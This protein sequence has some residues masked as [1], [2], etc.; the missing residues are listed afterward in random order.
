MK[1][2]L[3]FA[4]AAAV[5]YAAALA[6]LIA[7]LPGHLDEFLLTNDDYCYTPLPLKDDDGGGDT[8][9]HV[10]HP[11]IH[12]DYGEYKHKIRM[13]DH[14]LYYDD[15]TTNRE[16]RPSTMQEEQRKEEEV[17]EGQMMINHHGRLLRLL[18]RVTHSILWRVSLHLWDQQQSMEGDNNDDSSITTTTC[19]IRDEDYGQ[20]QQQ[21]MQNFSP[22][23]ELRWDHSKKEDNL[24]S[25]GNIH[26]PTSRSRLLHP[27][28][29]TYRKFRSCV[30]FQQLWL[31]WNWYYRNEFR[32]RGLTL[33]SSSEE[34]VSFV[35]IIREGNDNNNIVHSSS[36]S[37]WWRTMRLWKYF[38]N[39]ARI[40][41]VPRGGGGADGGAEINNSATTE[42]S[43]PQQQWEHEHSS[44]PNYYSGLPPQVLPPSV[45]IETVDISLTRDDVLSAQIQGV[46]INIVLQQGGLLALGAMP[47]QEALYLLPKPPEV[48]GL[49][50]RI[51]VLNV[52][53]VTLNLYEN[54]IFVRTGN[55]DDGGS[56]SSLK[57]LGK[58]RIPDKFFTP[59][60]NLTVANE[61]TGGIDQ[62]DFQPM[63][64]SSLSDALRQY[65]LGE[66]VATFRSSWAQAHK[67][68]EQLQNFF[69]V[70]T[71][72]LY[73]EKWIGMGAQAWHET[74]L[75][76]WNRVVN[77]TAPLVTAVKDI[78]RDL[79]GI[80]SEPVAPLAVVASHH[81][82]RTV[83]GFNKHGIWF[84]TQHMLDHYNELVSRRNDFKHENK[85]SKH[86][87]ELKYAFDEFVAKSSQDLELLVESCELEVKDMW[88]AWHR[89]F[90]PELPQDVDAND[91]IIWI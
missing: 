75:N 13:D 76:V 22:M 64:E 10:D 46:V 35:S 29:Q 16:R 81:W 71:Q 63:M 84:D 66:A 39:A 91:W 47:I 67:A 34:D 45:E 83:E 90:M 37:R 54:K 1:I 77:G 11:S 6:I 69:I 52:T 25:H 53:D 28:C 17:K 8:N 42:Q 61:R 9:G 55:Y 20:Q 2:S 65:V 49:F 89:Q 15:D 68:Q 31:P 85:I 70:Q 33:Q 5:A 87:S 27:M 57:L 12:V 41:V 72:E 21:F 7:I 38:V 56:L 24:Q 86:L 14:E 88:L 48:Y 82:N 44:P 79:K 51:G 4:A 78:V 36:S 40:E 3:V 18:R 60:T 32:M 23:N 43:P 58:M 62:K 73:L 80:V 26:H 19:P 59:V 30:R 50:P 74:Q